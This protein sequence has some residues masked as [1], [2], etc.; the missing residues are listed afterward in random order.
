MLASTRPIDKYG[1]VQIALRALEQMRDQIQRGSMPLHMNH[2]ATGSL[3]A[4]VCDVRIEQISDTEHAFFVDFE[5]DEDAW[6]AVESGWKAAGVPGG[7]SVA[8][9]EKQEEV[10]GP[11][12][13]VAVFASDAGAY[14]DEERAEA[15]RLISEVSSVEV[16]RLF[17]FSE[18]EFAKIA[19]EF[20]REVG[21]GLL[22]SAIGFLVGRRS[23]VSHIEMRR[24]EPDGTITTAILDTNNP[25]I[26]R[27]AAESLDS[28]GPGPVHR[29][30]VYNEETG[31]WEVEAL[32]TEASG[33]APS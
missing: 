21:A 16:L 33:E 26:V 6:A 24:K 27:A 32:A 14:T 30:L 15:A 8:V 28:R 9:T 5:A 1:G 4:N 17:Q 19:L 18:P 23:G 31:A 11:P 12:G 3:Q 2:R 7:F 10:D 25:E 20:S 13:S 22:V 29:L